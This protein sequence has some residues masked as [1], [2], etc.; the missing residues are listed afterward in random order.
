MPMR[1]SS[2]PLITLPA[3]TT[4]PN[5]VA[6]PSEVSNCST[7]KS[8]AQP[9]YTQPV[10]PTSA[11]VRNSTA[12]PSPGA[13]SFFTNSLGGGA[14]SFLASCA[15]AG[16]ATNAAVKTNAATFFNSMAPCLFVKSFPARH[17]FAARVGP[18]F[19]AVARAADAL[20]PT[21]HV[22]D[23]HLV[24]HRLQSPF[25]PF[26]FRAFLDFGRPVAAAEVGQVDGGLDIELPVEDTDERLGNVA[27]DEAA[28]GA[29]DRHVEIAA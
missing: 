5:G 16:A 8:L 19:P 11:A 12:S 25:D 22:D 1:P 24:T 4:R 21:G 18:A 14:Q 20:Q 27:D 9:S 13:M 2:Q 15:H 17:A 6:R 23:A 28:A 29:A 10:Y 26:E 7:L 3:P